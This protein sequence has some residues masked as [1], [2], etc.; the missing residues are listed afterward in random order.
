MG[1]SLETWTTRIRAFPPLCQGSF[2]DLQRWESEV[3]PGLLEESAR[4]RLT[5][6]LPGLLHL[7]RLLRERG[8]PYLAYRILLTLSERCGG[9]EGDVLRARAALYAASYGLFHRAYE[10]VR[11]LLRA[12]EVH[13]V[14]RVYAARVAS[15]YHQY[16]MEW[17][18]ALY[19]N[20]EEEIWIREHAAHFP[21]LE[22]RKAVVLLNRVHIHLHRLRTRTL[23][24]ISTPEE[25]REDLQAIVA[26]LRRFHR[27][28]HRYPEYYKTF[29]W[30]VLVETYLHAGATGRARRLIGYL[31]RNHHRY[32]SELLAAVHLY[33]AILEFQ[34]GET[35]A[36]EFLKEA[37]RLAMQ[38]GAFFRERD[39]LYTSLGMMQRMPQ[40]SIGQA[41]DRY[42][43][44]LLSLL[45]L[46]EQKDLYTARDH[47]LR[48]SWLAYWIGR[49][50]LRRA[51]G[52]ERW[53][54][55]RSLAV[56]GLLHDVGKVFLPWVVL[57]RLNPFS[58]EEWELI[59]FH[60]PYG[61]EALA[62]LGMPGLA[63]VVRE[64]HERMD[65][66]GYP[67][68]LSHHEISMMGAILAAAD[69]FE[70]ATS[71]NR[72]YRPPKPPEQVLREMEGHY[73][74]LVLQALGHLVRTGWVERDLPS[75]PTWLRLIQRGV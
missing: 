39:I 20:Q 52:Y 18:A 6:G 69:T 63:R 15:L 56:A 64:H 17:D 14:G 58:E 45:Q 1:T 24:G 71:P 46:L 57:N 9:P 19:W 38:S 42:R 50:L 30:S 44:L 27:L 33:R 72:K 23:R 47:A 12:S 2:E 34:E 66:S 75:L 36:L 60:V 5:N 61:V 13:P 62:M 65:G 8:D 54:F 35:T 49:E 68:G 55:P 73:H 10:Q 16:R 43:P 31:L 29:A 70:A 21:E 48:V 51:P 67:R 59:R 3:V 28:G 22:F 7:T 26:I 32:S 25:V 53:V 11:P 74:P 4:C 41:L 37:M 40:R